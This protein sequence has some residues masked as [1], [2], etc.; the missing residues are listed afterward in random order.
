MCV[1]LYLQN[2]YIHHTQIY[3][4]NNTD[5]YFTQSKIKTQTPDIFFSSVIRTL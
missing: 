1:Y 2:N 5:F 4:V 3:Y